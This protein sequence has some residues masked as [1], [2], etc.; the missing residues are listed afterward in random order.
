MLLSLFLT[1]SFE[2]LL[3]LVRPEQQRPPD[4]VGHDPD[5]LVDHAHVEDLVPGRPEQTCKYYKPKQTCK[6]CVTMFCRVR[7][8]ASPP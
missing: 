7:T 3:Y 1:Y 6:R 8:W 4:G 2:L 5:A